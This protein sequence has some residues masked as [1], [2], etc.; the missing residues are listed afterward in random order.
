MTCATPADT[1]KSLVCEP[2]LAEKCCL[3]PKTVRFQC[4]LCSWL[5]EA[6]LRG[7]WL[8]AVSCDVAVVGT[9]PTRSERRTRNG[10]VRC[11][12]HSTT[13]SVVRMRCCSAKMTEDELCPPL[14]VSSFQKVVGGDSIAWRRPG[15]LGPTA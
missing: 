7:A 4:I 2:Q 6:T 15:G 10:S 8:L 12:C 5:L 9:V 1:N 14:E 11:D 13:A 3:E